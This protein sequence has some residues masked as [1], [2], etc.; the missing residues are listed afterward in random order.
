MAEPFVPL[1]PVVE[2]AFDGYYPYMAPV[3][4][5]IPTVAAN[6]WNPDF[7]GH[8][9]AFGFG[10]QELDRAAMEDRAAAKQ[11]GEELMVLRT[12]KFSIAW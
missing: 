7:F 11:S 4:D 9:P 3:A 5:V 2:P 10:M 1:A 6:E 8:N 12:P